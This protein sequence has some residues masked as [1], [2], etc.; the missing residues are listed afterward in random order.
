M[1]Y[2][3]NESKYASKASKKSKEECFMAKLAQQQT[4]GEDRP[5]VI[6]SEGLKDDD[7]E[8]E[9]SPLKNPQIVKKTHQTPLIKACEVETN[10][11]TDNARLS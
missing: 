6:V 9:K 4:F 2:E 3:T 5:P 1:A 7:D 10:S 8:T 11:C